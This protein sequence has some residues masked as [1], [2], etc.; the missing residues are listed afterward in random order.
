MTTVPV[1]NLEGSVPT[2]EPEKVASETQEQ[3]PSPAD[4]SLDSEPKP[5][6]PV[7][8]PTEER[9]D[10]S[11]V[12]EA[13]EMVSA[14]VVSNESRE[15]PS[16]STSTEPHAE[17]GKLPGYADALSSTN[18]VEQGKPLVKVEGNRK[19]YG[20]LIVKK[21]KKQDASRSNGE[22]PVRQKSASQTSSDFTMD[23]ALNKSSPTT[24]YGSDE[25]QSKG[26]DRKDPA[27]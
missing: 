18:S 22:E 4:M 24:S 11:P 23:R 7:A 9:S 6:K 17:N 8:L 2:A 21:K 26:M 10:S 20:T 19:M 12:N 25:V 16:A 5:E 13:S 27:S 14:M 15:S 1:T 3:R